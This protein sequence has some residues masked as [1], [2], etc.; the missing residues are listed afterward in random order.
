[1]DNH[2]D[3]LPAVRNIRLQ[4]VGCW[5]NLIMDFIPA[6]NIITGESG[7]GK[8]TIIHAI[9]HAIHVSSTQNLLSRTSGYSKNSISV[10]LMSSKWTVQLNGYEEGMPVHSEN[11]SHGESTFEHLRATLKRATLN[12]MSLFDD[13]ILRSLANG[14][15]SD[16]VNLLN[17][18]RCQVI[19]V[20][21]SSRIDPSDFRKA[22]IYSCH[23]G[24]EEHNAKIRLLQPGIVNT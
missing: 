22:R 5:K 7:S 20:I 8:S 17:A 21:R 18:A 11:E 23:W 1:M 6:L 4:H 9:L 10:D 24:E 3:I 2:I 12:M 16:A 14:T 19:C 13:A 15:Y